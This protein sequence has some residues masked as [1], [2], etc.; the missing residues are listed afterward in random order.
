MLSNHTSFN[1]YGTNRGSVVFDALGKRSSLFLLIDGENFNK[2]KNVYI[3][4]IDQSNSI[5]PR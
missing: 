1:L 2:E 4:L 3:F 5:D